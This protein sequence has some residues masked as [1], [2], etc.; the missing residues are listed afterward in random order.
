MAA[1]GSEPTM[2]TQMVYSGKILNLRVDTVRMPNGR[3]VTREIAEHSNSVCVVPIDDQG[4]VLMVRQYRKPCE[5]DLLEVP[6]GGMEA[7]EA[8]DEAV[9]RELQEEIG[10]TAGRLHLLCSFW[11]APGWSTEYMHAYLATDLSPASLAGDY[12]ENISVVP[13]PMAEVVGLIE[14][15]EIQ[16]AKSIASLLLALRATGA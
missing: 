16:D 10:Y 3:M 8:A 13:V 5:S 4:N 1:S 2:D 6:A 14:A 7:N 12:D 11:V 9:L 15:G